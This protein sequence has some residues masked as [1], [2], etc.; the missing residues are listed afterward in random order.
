MSSRAKAPHTAHLRARLRRG[1]QRAA[2]PRAENE[3]EPCDPILKDDDF[4]RW[5][6]ISGDDKKKAKD[7]T[8]E[9]AQSQ[10]IRLVNSKSEGES[11]GK[12]MLCELLEKLSEEFR[13]SGRPYVAMCAEA[14]IE[15]LHE[16][17]QD[18]INPGLWPHIR[19]LEEEREVQLSETL[20]RSKR[21]VREVDK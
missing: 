18:D 8:S 2:R 16:N 11:D 7:I 9:D 13:A 21:V 10:D 14:A 6:N 5:V 4:H 3:N 20:A 15:L 19:R 12:K 1:V 17:R